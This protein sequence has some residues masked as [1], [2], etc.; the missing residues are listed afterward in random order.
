MQGISRKIVLT[1]CIILF[2]GVQLFAQDWPQWRGAN[3]D[4]K[5][6]GFTAPQ[7]WPKELT[8]KWKTV[9]GLGDATPALVGNRIYIFTR[10]GDNEVTL[11]LSAEDGKELWRDEYPA[12]AVTGPAGRHPG[13]RS[14]PAVAEEK[15]V[16]LGVAGVLSC[17]DA[18]NGKVVWRKDEYK[19]V[20]QFFTSISPII[21]DG[22]AIAH[23]GGKDK[24]SIVSFDLI[25]G[26]LKWKW[27]GDGPSYASPVLMSAEGTQQIIVQ[28]E[29]N[30]VSLVVAD[31]K[32]LWQIPSIPKER[33]YNSASPIVDGPMIIYTGQGEGTRA[34]KV[35]KQ[36]EGFGTKEI[37]SNKTIG[38]GY[39][40]PVMKEGLLF[41][42]SDKGNFFCLNAQTG[43]EAWTDTNQIDRFVEILDAGPVLMALSSKSE[44]IVFQPDA[45]KYHEIV[46]Y[47]VSDTP[48]YAYPI[49]SGNR[50]LI[51]DQ[52]SVTLRT[53]P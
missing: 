29:K 24:G 7:T 37:W 22:M 10:Q 28:T 14:S 33:F 27:D 1:G 2:G 20:P 19:E 50:L 18:A 25:T 53:I 15:V 26:E 39:N 38:T 16:T 3:R 43:Q 5:A 48:V 12:Q 45:A 41:G 11:C 4:G 31:G 47:K 40:T 36:A 23:L 42:V 9:V 52:D 34:L 46:R 32:L 44:L 17:L 6:S 30:L 51:K 21:I 8:Q 49:I 35:E 13:P